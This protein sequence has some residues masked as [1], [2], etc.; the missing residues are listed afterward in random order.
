MKAISNFAVS[1]ELAFAVYANLQI[2]DNARA[3]FVSNDSQVPNRRG[4]WRDI[5]S[6]GIAS[7]S[8]HRQ[9]DSPV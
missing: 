8:A 1:S 2:G 6:P 9:P 5:R 7:R 4:L 3:D